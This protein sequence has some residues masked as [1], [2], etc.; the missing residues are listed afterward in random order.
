MGWEEEETWSHTTSTRHI[1]LAITLRPCPPTR[2]R[3][4]PTTTA[5]ALERCRNEEMKRPH[6]FILFNVFFFSTIFLL[7]YCILRPEG[8]LYVVVVVVVLWC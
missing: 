7:V 5:D 4:L 3:R 2:R 1:N 6:R 8:V